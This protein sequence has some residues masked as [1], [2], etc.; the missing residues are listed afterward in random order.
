MVLLNLSA[1]C[2]YW[3]RLSF[4]IRFHS[5]FG[6]DFIKSV[7]AWIWNLY[8]NC[9]SFRYMKMYLHFSLLFH[10]PAYQYRNQ[11]A[12]SYI[13]KLNRNHLMRMIWFLF[14]QHVS[15]WLKRF[16]Q[17]L[18]RKHSH[19]AF[20]LRLN[21]QNVQKTYPQ[22][23]LAIFFSNY[24][25]TLIPIGREKKHLFVLVRL[26]VFYSKY[27]PSHAL[28]SCQIAQCDDG[29]ARPHACTPG[30]VNRLKT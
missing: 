18:Q 8:L 3:I 15:H 6:L 13:N 25:H 28:V 9:I 5:L 11:L 24:L 2:L 22:K 1:Y 4:S 10:D 17:V 21:E 23:S 20:H 30:A 19:F 7:C 27:W 29:R 26:F 14:N 12:S 16:D